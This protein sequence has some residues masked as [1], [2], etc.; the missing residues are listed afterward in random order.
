MK[1]K[2]I[3]VPVHIEVT[4]IEMATRVVKEKTEQY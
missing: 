1:T 3:L 2:V 4:E